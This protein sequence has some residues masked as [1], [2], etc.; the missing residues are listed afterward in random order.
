[1]SDSRHDDGA[2]IDPNAQPPELGEWPYPQSPPAPPSETIGYGQSG[3]PWSPP[4]HSQQRWSPGAPRGDYAPARTAHRRS[5][6]VIFLVAAIV[7]VGAAVAGHF[8]FFSGGSGSSPR[9]AAKAWLDAMNAQDFTKVQQL[10]CAQ[11]R[12][13]MVKSLLVQVFPHPG[14]YRITGTNLTD[15]K[16]ALVHITFPG[17]RYPFAQDANVPVSMHGG[18][19]VCFGMLGPAN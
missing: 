19:R 11:D 1:M 16:H 2:P 8:V 10:T 12:N 9:A 4:D 14:G 5:G 7:L 15:S 18:W 6:L 13:F 3:Y 17:F